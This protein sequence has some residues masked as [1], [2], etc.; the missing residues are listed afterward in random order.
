MLD[1]AMEKRRW[2]E[3]DTEP[4]ELARVMVGP[5][6]GSWRENKA[7]GL[8]VFIQV[9]HFCLPIHGWKNSHFCPKKK[10]LGRSES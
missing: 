10:Y 5:K 1:Q 6:S 9:D 2:E 3:A 7:K 8:E 4:A